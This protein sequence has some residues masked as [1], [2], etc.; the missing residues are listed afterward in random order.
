MRTIAG[1]ATAL[2]LIVGL[3][4]VSSGSHELGHTQVFTE[5]P[6][7]GMPEGIAVRE[8]V[9]YV[10]T[11]V[12]IRGNEGEGP[13]KIFLYGLDSGA[14][15]DEITI[16][17]QSLDETH[18]ILSMAFDASGRLYVLDRNPPRM[19]RIDLST[20]P[21]TQADY[22][23]FPD[24]VPC[25]SAPEGED[26]SPTALDLDPFPDYFAFDAEGN[27]YVT[28]LEQATI[29]RV[30]PTSSTDLPAEAAIW[31]QDER[32]DS[33][34]GPNG[35]ALDA[36][37]DTIFFAMTGAVRPSVTDGQP[38]LTSQGVIYTLP[39]VDVPA[40]DDLG[41]FHVYPDPAA[42]P[43]GIA[44]GESGRLYVALA[45]ANQ[46][47]VLDAEGSEVAR[48]PTPVENQMQ[49]VPYD[50]P[51]SIAFKDETRS[52]L[53][54]NQSF[55]LAESDHWVVFEAFVDDTGL[56]LREPDIGG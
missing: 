25:H 46:I 41:A 34:F 44:F 29:F 7:P 40:A 9:V 45:G 16:Q 17:G 27:A 11:H 6:D 50:L 12:S 54:T 18:G 8:G 2:L 23:T 4:G 33:V 20:D 56:P 53:V 3:P 38:T 32:L 47:S 22:A 26:C 31:F 51:A 14:P 52:I 39:L 49:D 24:L 36:D 5:V 30:P 10:G 48:F 21:P 1:L 43:D 15:L 13:S 55:F 42:G 19:I 28:D 35:I 37:G